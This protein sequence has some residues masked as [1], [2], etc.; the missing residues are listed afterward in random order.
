MRPRAVAGAARE[1]IV[2]PVVLV[3]VCLFLYPMVVLV[4]G[5]LCVCEGSGSQGWCGQCGVVGGGGRGGLLVACASER[6]RKV[7]QVMLATFAGRRFCPFSRGDFSIQR[8]THTHT[9]AHARRLRE[10][11][12]A[13][14]LPPFALNQSVACRQKLAGCTPRPKP[15]CDG[16]RVRQRARRCRCPL[17]RRSPVD[18]TPQGEDHPRLQS[19]LL[20]WG[21]HTPNKNAPPFLCREGS[22]PPP[23]CCRTP[24]GARWSA[25]G[26]RRA[27]LCSRPPQPSPKRPSS[28]FLPFDADD[29]RVCCVVTPRANA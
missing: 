20:S 13:I 1:R 24:D 17:A 18:A 29:R 11:D 4:D 23:S 7:E 3:D 12:T 2:C 21:T 5:R 14:V 16:L 26:G 15:F 27:P 19:A 9:Q 22:P 8:H 10:H 25:R 28:L 6:A